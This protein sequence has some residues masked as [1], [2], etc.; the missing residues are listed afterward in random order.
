MLVLFLVGIPLAIFLGTKLLYITQGVALEQR[1]GVEAMKRSWA[2]TKGNFWRTLGYAI[3]P[4]LAV[5]VVL[6]LAIPCRG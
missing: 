3:L 1:G 4:Q 6:P 2:L 5:G